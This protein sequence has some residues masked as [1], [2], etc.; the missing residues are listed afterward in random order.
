MM[1]KISVSMDTSLQHAVINKFE[2]KSFSAI[3]RGCLIAVLQDPKLYWKMQYKIHNAEAILALE[4]L[5]TIEQ[6]ETT[7]ED[8]KKKRLL[9]LEKEE[10][11]QIVYGNAG[12]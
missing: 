5:K 2:N 1:K 7:L 9:D 8:M 12:W 10:N 6:T 11:P 3:I 4:Q